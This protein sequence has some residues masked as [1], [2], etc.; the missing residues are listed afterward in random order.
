M[1]YHSCADSAVCYSISLR[2]SGNARDLRSGLRESS[3]LSRFRGDAK[4]M[5]ARG[6][7]YHWCIRAAIVVQ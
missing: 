3:G 4:G 5:L 2:R 6:V 1:W 7:K